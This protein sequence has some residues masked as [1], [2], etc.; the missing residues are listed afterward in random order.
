MEKDQIDGG[1][2]GRKGEGKDEKYLTRQFVSF[3][4]TKIELIQFLHFFITCG[5]YI[6]RAVHGCVHICV[7]LYVCD[8]MHLWT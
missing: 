8:M 3:Q 1:G 6:V 5:E 7:Y 2:K 4:I